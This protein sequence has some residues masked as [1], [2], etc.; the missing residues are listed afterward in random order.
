[1]YSRFTLATLSSSESS[2]RILKRA[3]HIAT[4]PTTARRRNG[5]STVATARGIPHSYRRHGE[6]P[7]PRGTL[8]LPHACATA[9][10]GRARRRE[11]RGRGGCEASDEDAAASLSGSRVRGDREEAEQNWG[12]R[13]AARHAWF[14]EA[15][16]FENCWPLLSVAEAAAKQVSGPE[17]RW[18]F[19][20]HR[21]LW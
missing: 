7:G 8:A 14:C 16:C 6:L 13:A 17:L 18:V 21:E 1:M 3:P 5:N 10:R 4:K 2:N 20:T 9:A 19:Q 12:F 11:G 15:A